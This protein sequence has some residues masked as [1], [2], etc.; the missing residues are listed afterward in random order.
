M[1]F[2][3]RGWILLCLIAV[4][5][6]FE[7]CYEYGNFRTLTCPDSCCGT[8]SS[9]YCCPTV[10]FGHLRAVVIGGIVTGVV[11]LIAAIA[12]IVLCCVCCCRSSQGHRGQ[13]VT[14][15]QQLAVVSTG[16]NLTPATYNAGYFNP[17]Q[18]APGPYYPHLQERHKLHHPTPPDHRT[19]QDKP[20]IQ[21]QVE[22]SLLLH[23]L[24]IMKTTRNQP[25]LCQ[26]ASI[27]KL[28]Y[29]RGEDVLMSTI[30]R[31]MTFRCTSLLLHQVNEKGHLMKE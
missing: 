9:R 30:F 14:T 28:D 23:I 21:P 13:V 11:L 7:T 25:K 18:P 5:N 27:I 1:Y 8:R 20:H 12:G 2:M 4:S 31:N 22:Q 19:T 29:S 24:L 10:S 16:T 26:P 17:P 15:N 6:A 3:K